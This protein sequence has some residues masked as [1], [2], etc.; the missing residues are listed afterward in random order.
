MDASSAMAPAADEADTISSLA[1]SL[2]L[3][4][5]FAEVNFR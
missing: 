5:K 4:S 2:V 3:D 1:L